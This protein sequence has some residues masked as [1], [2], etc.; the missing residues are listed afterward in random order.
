MLGPKV[1]NLR[2]NIH[3]ITFLKMELTILT[4]LCFDITKKRHMIV[5]DGYKRILDYTRKYCKNCYFKENLIQ[6]CLDVDFRYFVAKLNRWDFLKWPKQAIFGSVWA[7]LEHYAVTTLRVVTSG[8]PPL[9]ITK[10]G[11]FKKNLGHIRYRDN[12]CGYLAPALW[13]CM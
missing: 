7:L 9:R 2:E 12:L 3:F 13:E 1:I 8:S 5:P 6:Y 10:S 11:W 4:H